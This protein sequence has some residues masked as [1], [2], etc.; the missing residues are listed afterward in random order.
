[1]KSNAG[2]CR[3]AKTFCAVGASTSIVSGAGVWGSVVFDADVGMLTC[4]KA[5]VLIPSGRI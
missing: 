2:G 5:S 4:P 1:M 3:G